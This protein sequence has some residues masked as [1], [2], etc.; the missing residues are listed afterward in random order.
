[1]YEALTHRSALSDY[2]AKLEKRSLGLNIAMLSWNE[3]L[4]FLGDSV[5][6]LAI[7]TMLWHFDGAEEFAEGDLSRARASLV[8]ETTLAEIAANI[9]LGQVILLGKGELK[10]GARSRA[11]LLADTLEALIGA[12]Y[13]D[14]GFEEAKAVVEVLFVSLFEGNLSRLARDFKTQLQE[15]TQE[16]YKITPRYSVVKETGPDHSKVFQVAVKISGKVVATARGASKKRASQHA[17]KEALQII[18][19]R[20]K[21]GEL[22]SEF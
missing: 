19:S 4:E 3:R 12:V 10:S 18:A 11:S 13:L 7:S 1:M 5:L 21:N 9:D 22:D 2:T 15:L 6:N 20:L 14:S 17:A 16:I 8:N